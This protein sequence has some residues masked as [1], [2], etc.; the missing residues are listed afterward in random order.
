MI[1]V[2][3]ALILWKFGVPESLNPTGEVHRIVSQVDHAAIGKAKRYHRWS[4]I[5]LILLVVGFAL[6]LVG[7]WPSK[8][9]FWCA[10]PLR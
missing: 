4:R 1:S 3:A 6:Q 5:G 9:A 10:H 8:W 7:S 2:I